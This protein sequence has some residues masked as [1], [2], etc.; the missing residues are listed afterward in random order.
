VTTVTTGGQAKPTLAQKWFIGAV[1]LWALSVVFA[2][3]GLLLGA[4]FLVA[5]GIPLRRLAFAVTVVWL[6]LAVGGALWQRWQ[7]WR[8]R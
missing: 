7:R 4:E 8:R 3:L 1:A 2:L 5:F 6:L